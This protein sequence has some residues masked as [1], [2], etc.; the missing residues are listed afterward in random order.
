[1]TATVEIIRPKVKCNKV[2]AL[3]RP[4]ISL[5][6]RQSVVQ[7]A[8]KNPEIR[9]FLDTTPMVESD[10]KRVLIWGDTQEVIDVVSAKFKVLHH[11]DAVKAALDSITKIN[12]YE[13]DWSVDFH[14]PKGQSVNVVID[15]PMV[16]SI[17]VT[18]G[19]FDTSIGDC[20]RVGD[21]DLSHILFKLVNSYGRISA[22]GH[23][24]A[25]RLVCTNGMK[26]PMALGSYKHKHTSGL[27]LEQMADSFQLM[28][29]NSV[30]IGPVYNEWSRE[31]WEP[32]DILAAASEL[33]DMGMPQKYTRRVADMTKRRRT[34]KWD[35][36]NLCTNMATHSTKSVASR[37]TMDRIVERCFWDVDALALAA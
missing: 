20:R 33:K 15:A 21:I 32:S 30:K 25:K 27:D 37:D 19:L 11:G 2:P 10:E 1:M 29:K 22:Y 13:P 5:P 24:M 28:A 4:V 12:G 16:P 3:N 7:A 14:G 9:Q 26:V 36:Y 6:L 31:V 18:E 8:E 23:L 35:A 34:T 17:R